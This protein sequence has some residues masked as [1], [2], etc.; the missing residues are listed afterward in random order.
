MKLSFRRTVLTFLA[1]TCP[2]AQA[3]IGDKSDKRG[4]VQKSLVPRELI[5][6]SPALSVVDALKSF[7]LQPGFHIECV[8]SEPLVEDP[9]VA[10]FDPDGRLWVVEMRGFMPDLDGNGEDAPVGRV[11]VLTDTDGD[12]KMDK[13]TV[14]ADGLVLPRALAFVGGGV[15]VG[16]PPHLYFLRDTNGDGK[17]DEKIEIASDFGVAVDPKRPE[18]ANPERE[19][20]SLLWGIDNWIYGAAYMTRFKYDQGEWKHGVTIFRGQWGLS[21]DENGRLFYNSNSDQLRYDAIPSTYIGRN[22]NFLQAH[23]NNVNA[24]ENQFVWPAR[25]NPGINR[26]YRPDMLRDGRLKEYTAA[27][28]P[29][30][31]YSDLFPQEFYGNVFVAEPAGNLVRRNILS[32]TNGAVLGKNPYD[33]AE[34]LASTDERFRPVHFTTGPDGALYIVD[35]YR[36]VLQHRISLT[37]YLRNQSAERNLD[38][39]IHLGRIY[40]VV[41]DGRDAMNKAHFSVE[42]PLQ[43]I[44]HLSHSNDW[45]RFTAQR[46]LVEK[47]DP[48]T[49]PALKSLALN[50]AQPLG[51]LHALWTLDGLKALDQSTAQK[52][53]T[54]KDARV[55][56]AAMRLCENF[57]DS[58][59]KA[60]VLNKLF[61]LKTDAA[62]EVQL[63]L[64]LTLGEAH[65]PQADFVLANLATTAQTNAFLPDAILS[66]VHGRELELLRKLVSTLDWKKPQGMQA[67]VLSGLAACVVIQRQPERVQ[68]LLALIADCGIAAQQQSLLDGIASTAGVTTKK[69]VKLAKA[70]Q[71]L[72]VLAGDTNDKISTRGKKISALFTWAGKP[73]A[74]P[75]PVIPP[76]TTE[77]QKR[78]E[79]GKPLFLGSCAACHQSHGMGMEGLAPPLVDSE[80]VLGSEQRLVRIALNGLHGPIKVNG[81]GYQLD[82]PSMGLFD[83][84]QLAA[85]LTYIRRE[86]DNGG[87]P[88]DSAT[89]KA[90]RAANAKR[91]EAWSSDELLKIQ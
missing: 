49:I 90:I 48:V 67:R 34:F 16:A 60:E 7:K 11:V 14:F 41:P 2:L 53:L 91:Q 13:S 75:E 57:F 81:K 24:A 46:L 43:W 42:S 62:P 29:Y 72:T 8:A 58:E 84:E 5:P 36:G 63:Q 6:P 40:R 73:G 87:S 55:R 33:K 32:E 71:A 1:A 68:Q 12:G 35:L 86:W 54:D 61:A 19:P 9:V 23:G 83:D 50:G 59:E 89:V 70:P 4:E 31:F 56:A 74:K 20:N 77:Q 21:Q 27:C 45:W 85:I 17:A 52:A 3:Q 88:V 82:M 22:P 25:V 76:L 15:L 79:A 28:S 78:F 51:R 39:P 26:G 65:D 44:D 66:S 10:Q 30:V 64:A 47:H 69:P 80:W 18:L 38:K 37:T